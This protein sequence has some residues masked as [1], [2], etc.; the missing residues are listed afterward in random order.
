MP[1][2]L[3]PVLPVLT[4]LA[5]GGLVYSLPLPPGAYLN[6]LLVPLAVT[7]WYW[8]LG[9]GLLAAGLG[10]AGLLIGVPELWDVIHTSGTL[11]DTA[12][13]AVPVAVAFCFAQFGKLY[14]K[15]RVKDQIIKRAELDPLTGLLNRAALMQRL[16]HALHDAEMTGSVLAV[17]F[18]DLD[19]FKLVNDSFGHEV[20]D[21]LLVNVAECLK[22]NIRKDDFVARLGGDEFVVVLQALKEAK[23]AAVV[24]EKLVRR[25]SAPWEIQG[26]FVHVSA[27]IG[28]SVFPTDGRDANTLTTSADHAMYKIKG[29]GKND[30]VF[31]T[32]ELQGQQTRRLQLERQLRWALED[33]HFR[34]HY[35][36]QVNL[37]THTVEAFEVLLR[38]QNPELGLISPEEFIPLAEEA[39]L[40]IPIGHWLLREACAQ[41]AAWQREG[42]LP[43]RMAV[44]VSPLQF[45]QPDFAAHVVRA[46]KDSGLAP[47]WLEVEI[48]EGLL[49][50]DLDAATRM[51]RKLQKVGVRTVLDDFGTGYSSLAYLH[52]LPI[53]TLKIDRSFVSNLRQS[54]AVQAS[55]IVIIEAICALA[56]KLGKAIVA[57][58]VETEGQRDFLTR[59]GC[60]YAQ[61]YLFSRPLEAAQVTRFLKRLDD[62]LDLLPGAAGGLVTGF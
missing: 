5:Y 35:Q 22:A 3:T 58:G 14:R 29:S 27:S 31:S 45:S 46:L 28:I 50:S 34:L 56:H 48:T 2:R 54:G 17:L 57:E 16:E 51:L 52:Q 61:G 41:A 60:D 13:F 30:Y 18:V 23:S 10:L 20:G 40:I 37:Q 8:G 11:W 6:T 42:F 49:I 7:G 25:I 32:Q 12:A 15:G 47:E 26:K 36:P 43:V 55:N 9:L 39:G 38:W 59:L 33:G 24:A 53:G 21:A 62:E 1:A 4:W 19:R 44:N